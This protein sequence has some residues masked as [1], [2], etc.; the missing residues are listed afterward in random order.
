MM[1]VSLA[2]ALCLALTGCNSDKLPESQVFARVNGD[3]LSIHQLNFSLNKIAPKG[4]TLAERE[5]LAE[6]SLT[7][8]WLFRRHEK[9]VGSS[10]RGDDAS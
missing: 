9:W 3:E 4:V 5:A 6:S 8:S 10:S 7:V 1:R 2:I